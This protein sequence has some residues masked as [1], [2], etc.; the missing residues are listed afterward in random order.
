MYIVHLLVLLTLLSFYFLLYCIMRLCFCQVTWEVTGPDPGFEREDILQST[1]QGV[2]TF[3]DQQTSV[4][5]M[6][7]NV[8]L[9]PLSP[10][11]PSL[12]VT[13]SCSPSPLLSLIIVIILLLL[14]Y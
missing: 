5:L 6:N 9:T 8:L 3:D 7:N 4:P 2:L 10:L 12:S 13:S 14:L 11:S 1:L